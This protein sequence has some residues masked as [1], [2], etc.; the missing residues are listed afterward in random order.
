MAGNMRIQLTI[1]LKKKKK[2]LYLVKRVALVMG[3][4][5]PPTTVTET[6]G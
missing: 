5:H 1:E 3:Y 4:S 2:K 6:A